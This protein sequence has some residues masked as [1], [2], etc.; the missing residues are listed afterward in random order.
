[1]LSTEVQNL[2]IGD[3]AKLLD[4]TTY[5]IRWR[6]SIGFFVDREGQPIVPGR[7]GA[8]KTLRVY[9][10]DQVRE[11]AHRMCKASLITTEGLKTILERIDVLSKTV[12]KVPYQRTGKKDK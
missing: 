12:E 1:M 10:P 11:M 4:V 6:E 2:K 3:V 7:T 5:W 8:N 9:S